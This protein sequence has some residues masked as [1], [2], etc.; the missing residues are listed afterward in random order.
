MK[1]E[2]H[3]KQCLSKFF[4]GICNS[5]FPRDDLCSTILDLSFPPI[6]PCYS[7]FALRTHHLLSGFH[8]LLRCVP[9]V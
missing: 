3:Q 8:N 5:S 7:P 4:T 1:E 2:R 6:L 9:P